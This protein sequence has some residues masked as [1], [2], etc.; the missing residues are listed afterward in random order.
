MKPPL[1]GSYSVRNMPE[2]VF[3]AALVMD[4]CIRFEDKRL[5]SFLFV[6]GMIEWSFREEKGYVPQ[7]LLLLGIVN[8]LC[9]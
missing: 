6:A 9:P 5:I 1:V 8:I 3:S 4:A 7:H 2:G